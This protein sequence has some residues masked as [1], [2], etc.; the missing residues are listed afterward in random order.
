MSHH[1]LGNQFP[2]K[3]CVDSSADKY[4][5]VHYCKVSNIAFII[6]RLQIQRIHLQISG[7][8]L[9]WQASFS[10]QSNSPAIAPNACCEPRKS[11]SRSIELK[12][13]SRGR[14]ANHEIFSLIAVTGVGT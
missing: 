1:F 5:T 3:I 2:R 12:R 6:N 14:E 10:R 7:N 11:H 4:N 9:A 13:G 8:V